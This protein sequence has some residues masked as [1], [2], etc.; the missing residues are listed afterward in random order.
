M[1]SRNLFFKLQ[2]EDLK[3]RLW[4]AALSMLIFFLFGPV[5]LALVLEGLVSDAQMQYTIS[6][7]TSTIGPGFAFHF[8]ISITGALICASSGFF[9]LHSR[10]KVDFYHGVPVR[11][12]VLFAVNY[13]DGILL[14]LIPYLISMLLNFVVLVS[15]GY[16]KANVAVIGFEALGIN[17][18]YFIL[19]YTLSVLAV[20]LTGNGVISLLLTGVFYSYGPLV[21]IIKDLYCRAFF[22]TYFNTSS[23]DKLFL[24]L[25]PIGKYVKNSTLIK[26]GEFNGMGKSIALTAIVIILIMVLSV[27]LY[28]KRPS[29]AAGKAIAFNIAKPFI[30]FLLVLPLS[31]G[32][33]LL[34][35]ETAHLHKDVWMIFGLIL[36]FVIASAIIE[37]IHQFDLKKAFAHRKG[38]AVTA[39]AMVI[40]VCLFRFDLISYDSYI[41][42]K[43]KVVSMSIYVPGLDDNKNYMEVSKTGTD[44]IYNSTFEYQQKYMRLK[45]IN[46]AYDIAKLGIMEA[47]KNNTAGDYGCTVAFHL[48][49]GRT[50]LRNYMAVEDKDLTLLDQ[51]YSS[52]DYKEGYYPI[53][54][55]ATKYVTSVSVSS[56]KTEKVLT[57]TEA[58]KE[59]LLTIYKEELKGLTIDDVKMSKPVATI[60]FILINSNEFNYDVFPKFTKTREFL[61]A[62]GLNTDNPLMAADIKKIN[63]SLQYNDTVYEKRGMQVIKSDSIANENKA[64]DY[65]DKEKIDQILK[66]A[67]P[68]EYCNDFSTV[69][70]PNYDIAVSVIYDTDNYGNERS[71][72]YYFSKGNIPDFVLKDL[73]YESK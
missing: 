30:K 52:S 58:E 66:T 51:V 11:R 41:P 34:F 18:L 29:E 39:F 67:L 60:R 12:E 46:T 36:I 65:T 59:E 32:G 10:K 45:D 1:I 3:R 63:V 35:R 47:K 70:K 14:Y 40:I 23:D 16:L 24:F 4:V 28:K 8:I 48:K 26:N 17:L 9:Y 56:D 57:L 55:W 50:V 20:V 5:L 22:Q 38:L 42:A 72:L 68:A 44:F 13:V 2:K 37:I 53:Y 6:Q 27:L 43:D 19:L 62:H 21:M 25:S 73:N 49:N 54:K 7:I 61:S 31:L 64:V 69:L 15:A 71:D 33:G